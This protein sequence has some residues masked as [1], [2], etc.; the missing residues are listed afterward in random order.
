MTLEFDYSWD[1][2]ILRHIKSNT[3]W[4]FDAYIPLFHLLSQDRICERAY[5]HHRDTQA[6]AG[7]QW[8]QIRV[9]F[10]KSS[11]LLSKDLTYFGRRRDELLTR[12]SSSADNNDFMAP[13]FSLIATLCHSE[14]RA[15]GSGFCMRQ[16]L[17]TDKVLCTLAS[18]TKSNSWMM[19]S[20]V[21]FSGEGLY[22]NDYKGVSVKNTRLWETSR[23]FLQVL[24][25]S[26]NN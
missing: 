18:S 13:F 7:V 19:Q 16:N 24:P 10:L 4:E 14:E 8:D 20:G 15:S 9:M 2:A 17:V 1:Y 22:K 21:G 26:K 25:Y 12:A 3:Y 11:S 6:R 23:Y 5:D